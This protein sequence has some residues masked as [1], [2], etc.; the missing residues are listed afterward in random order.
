MKGKK[1]IDAEFSALLQD[2]LDCDFFAAGSE[3]AGIAEIAARFGLGA[4]DQRQRRIWDESI[5]PIVSKP[6]GE[7]VAVRSI[8]RNGGYLPQK[9]D[10]LAYPPAGPLAENRA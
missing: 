7:Q 10:S 4:L 6:L 2:F 1:R 9:I 5:L 3:E 8:L